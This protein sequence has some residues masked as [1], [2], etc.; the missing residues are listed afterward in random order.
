MLTTTFHE[1]GD[2]R[3]GARERGAGIAGLASAVGVFLG[4]VIARGPGWRWV[5]FVNPPVCVLVLGG[6]FC[7]ARRRAAPA[8][9]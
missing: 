7:A 8:P 6:A 3:Q 1:G 2:R 4:G 5:F 9:A